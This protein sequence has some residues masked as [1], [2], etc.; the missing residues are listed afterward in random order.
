MSRLSYL[1]SCAALAALGLIESEPPPLPEKMPAY[2]DEE[3]LGV[4]LFRMK[5]TG[6]D[7]SNMTLPRTFFS[8]SLFGHCSWAGSDLT[9]S[10]LC[11]NEFNNCD[12]SQAILANAD[13]RASNFTGCIFDGADLHNADLRHSDFEGC[14]F[15]GTV[16]VGA[17][18]K[19]SQ[20]A[21]LRLDA[22]HAASLVVEADL[23]SD[24]PDGG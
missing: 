21:D 15:K 10:N 23:P 18:A 13:L 1:D 3:P 6:M 5:L 16:L 11:W 4:S 20:L 8:R 14:S 2:D 12:F 19:Q 17:R 24:M 9:Q 7:L 22:A